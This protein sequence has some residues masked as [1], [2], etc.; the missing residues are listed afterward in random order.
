MRVFDAHSGIE[1]ERRGSSREVP[2]LIFR[3]ADSHQ[4]TPKL[5]SGNFKGDE[6]STTRHHPDSS[7]KASRAEVAI[8]E[9]DVTRLISI[10]Y[11][12]CAGPMIERS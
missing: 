4:L 6:R 12:D 5:H 7:R 8:C 1:R 9:N 2:R 3:T 10:V 11:H